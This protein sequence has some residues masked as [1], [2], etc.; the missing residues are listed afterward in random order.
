MET[1]SLVQCLSHEKN[2]YPVQLQE[3]QDVERRFFKCCQQIVLIDQKLDIV[4]TRYNRADK[5]NFRS[6]RYSLRLQLATV[7][8]VRNAYYEYA[9]SKAQKMAQL[10]QVLFGSE[11]AVQDYVEIPE[12]EDVY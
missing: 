3:L 12:D 10:R 2:N 11:I 8:G 6:L 4:Q 5:D 1:S 9:K 7:E